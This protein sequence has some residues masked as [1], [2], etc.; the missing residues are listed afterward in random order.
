MKLNINPLFRDLIPGLTKDEYSELENSL[1]KDGCLDAIKTW[2]G[3]II[4]G[5]NRYDICKKNKIDFEV[6]E[7][8]LDSEDDAKIWI[9]K[10]QFGRRN[11]N[12][13]QRAMLALEL[14]PLIAEQAN[15]RMLTGKPVDPVLISTQ[16]RTRTKIADI[17]G[18]GETTIYEAKK[19]K[20]E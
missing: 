17:A 10:N 6:M 1:K 14:E 20:G 19:S 4:D 11:I 13:A 3:T 12:V 16:G 15:Q 5:H 9:I 18:I 7:M 8:E 2:N